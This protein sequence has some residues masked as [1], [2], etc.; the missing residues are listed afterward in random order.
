MH[1]GRRGGSVRGH[2]GLENDAIEN[3]LEK[4]AV[5]P[6]IQ[7][8]RIVDMG[9]AEVGTLRGYEACAG[10][11]RVELRNTS[12][13]NC[14][15]TKYFCKARTGWQSCDHER[16]IYIDQAHD[17]IARYFKINVRSIVVKVRDL[18]AK[19]RE[20]WIGRRLCRGTC[21]RIQAGNCS[22]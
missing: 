5:I 2:P 18:P 21:R 1:R 19:R 9:F 11:A 15:S 10:I 12:W 7:M 22:R 8:I 20:A 17:H 3:V 6:H 16:N 4:I 14:R 13:R